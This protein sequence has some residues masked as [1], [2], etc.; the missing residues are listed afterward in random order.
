MGL[1]GPE[2]LSPGFFNFHSADRTSS[3]HFLEQYF[4]GLHFKID[5]FF[6]NRSPH[7]THVLSIF[8]V[9]GVRI[10][11][12][13]FGDVANRDY[14]VSDPLKYWTYKGGFKTLDVFNIFRPIQMKSRQGIEPC[15]FRWSYNSGKFLPLNYRTQCGGNANSHR[16]APKSARHFVQ[17]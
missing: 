2:S 3:S 9:A 17:F 1:S 6:K 11:L 4:A 8:I 13:H 12:T 15:I 7:L 14:Q 5:L 10:E 16:L